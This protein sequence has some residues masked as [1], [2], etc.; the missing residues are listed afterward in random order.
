[1]NK[2]K[3]SET[4]NKIMENQN[5]Q[6]IMN[7]AQVKKVISLWGGMN[8]KVKYG[9]VA[10]F[11]ALIIILMFSLSGGNGGNVGRG[12]T[13]MLD[14]EDIAVSMTCRNKCEAGY[15]GYS[16]GTLY[17]KA[18]D[19]T[20]LYLIESENGSSVTTTAEESEIYGR[21]SVYDYDGKLTGADSNNDGYV[22]FTISE[23]NGY[24]FDKVCTIKCK[25]VPFM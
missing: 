6:K 9:I 8:K 14:N 18:T 23:Y 12:N 24:G 2:I 11:I 10:G 15:V 20:I 16:Y 21:T 17:F 22:E 19:H 7:N 13:I 25:Y 4:Y 5:V 1:M 3:N